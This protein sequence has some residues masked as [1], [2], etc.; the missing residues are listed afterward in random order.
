MIP[1]L[2][3]H[4]HKEKDMMTFKIRGVNSD[5]DT[6]QCCGK[7]NL[8]KVIWLDRLEEGE[9]IE[10]VAYGV[11]CAARAVR[12]GSTAVWSTAVRRDEVRE[13]EELSQIHKVGGERSV[14]ALV[15]ESISQNGRTT[16]LGYA[17]GLKPAVEAWAAERWPQHII[18]VRWAI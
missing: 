12:M 3:V 14:R 18:N 2:Q 5:L 11:N 8:K 10:T 6:C 17:N 16:I 15:I 1:T 4:K 9:V 7:I 13:R